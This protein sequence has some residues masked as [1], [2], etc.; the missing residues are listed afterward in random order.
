[1]TVVDLQNAMD[2]V[3]SQD[4]VNLALT[5]STLQAQLDLE[6]LNAEAACLQESVHAFHLLQASET[7]AWQTSL[8]ELS[9]NTGLNLPKKLR[10]LRSLFRTAK[11]RSMRY[12]A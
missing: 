10:L 4:E 11:E 12:G 9:A 6:Q 8:A 1:M 3:A 2:G 5:N 7:Q